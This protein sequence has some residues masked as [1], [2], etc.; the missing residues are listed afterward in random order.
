MKNCHYFSVANCHLSLLVNGDLYYPTDAKAVRKVKADSAAVIMKHPGHY[1]M[2]ENPTE[3]KRCVAVVV[4]E[5][6]RLSGG[7]RDRTSY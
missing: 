7:R 3:F 5:R 1:P 4:E 2:P 6:I